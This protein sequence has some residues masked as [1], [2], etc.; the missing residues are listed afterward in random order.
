[1]GN[2]FNLIMLQHYCRD[3]CFWSI[4]HLLTQLSEQQSKE[5]P[6][7]TGKGRTEVILNSHHLCSTDELYMDI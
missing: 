2:S 4:L 7:D 3:T 6:S 5:Q 1:M